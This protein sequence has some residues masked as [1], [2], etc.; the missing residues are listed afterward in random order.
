MKITFIPTSLDHKTPKGL[1]M[2][3]ALLVR[4][5]QPNQ[6]IL[7]NTKV[8]YFDRL[9]GTRGTPRGAWIS[10]RTVGDFQLSDL[11][12]G[13]IIL[14]PTSESFHAAKFIE[15]DMIVTG[16]LLAPFSAQ[17]SV[18]A[19]AAGLETSNAI[20]VSTTDHTDDIARKGLQVYHA[21]T[22]LYQSNPEYRNIMLKENGVTQSRSLVNLVSIQDADTQRSLEMTLLSLSSGFMSRNHR[23]TSAQ[24][25]LSEIPFTE[26]FQ[27]LTEEE[28]VGHFIEFS[29]M[30]SSEKIE[31]VPDSLINLIKESNEYKHSLAL[32]EQ[33]GLGISET[34]QFNVLQQ[35][36]Y[37]SGDRQNKNI[38]Y[39]LSDMGAGKTL[40]TVQSIAILDMKQVDTWLESEESV[41][42]E[43]GFR[44]PDK[45]IITPTLSVTSSWISTFKMFYDVEEIDDNT[46]R[47]ILEYR[48]R[49]V[50]SFIYVAP[51]TIR[52]GLTFVGEKLPVAAHYTYLIIDEIHQLVKKPMSKTKFFP[53]KTMPA[54]T[55]K[56]FVLSGTM[57]N[58]LSREWL[59]YMRFMGLP[60]TH[61]TPAASKLAI[62][63]LRTQMG[64]SISD[65]VGNI[66]TRHHRQI[67]TDVFTRENTHI[68]EGPNKITS[69]DEE[70]F[71]R[72]G[73]QIINP[74]FAANEGAITFENI[75]DQIDNNPGAFMTSSEDV[76]TTNFQLFYDIVG[77]QSITA[78]SSTIAEE[79]FGDQ[80]I[81]H[82]SDIIKTSSPLTS[83][84]IKILKVLHNIAEDHSQYKSLRIAKD[85]NTAILNLNDGLQTKNLYDILSS[86]AD[87]NIRFF[88]YLSTLELDVLRQLPQSNLIAMPTL[89]ETEKFQILLDILDK[90]KDETHLI[91]VN[92]FQAMT[93]ISNA[94]GVTSITRAQLR[95]ELSYQ[96]TL[97]ELFEKQSIVVVTQDMIKSS[98][99]LIQA[100]RL[101]QYQLNTEISDIIQTQNRINRI[102]QTR[103]TRG[104]YIASDAL[105]ENLIEL[106]LTSYQNIRVAHK[107]IVELFV[108]VTSQINIVNNYLSKAFETLDAG[109]DDDLIEDNQSSDVM[110]MQELSSEQAISAQNDVAQALLVPDGD[111][112]SVIVPLTDGSAFTLGTLSP[113]KV[114]EFNIAA[115]MVATIN[116]ETWE[117]EL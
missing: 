50:E 26:Y 52:G 9:P 49:K 8:T 22:G 93:K 28:Q 20:L 117:V 51:F 77:A 15:V 39:N 59:N 6:V 94:L 101:I 21:I 63:S 29:K 24:K 31:Y 76:D 107:G 82:I 35:V 67:D 54:Q 2:S 17:P 23:Q 112:V 115:P 109:E 83:E 27:L 53:P 74:H 41:T 33:H 85:I 116:I 47:L 100:N 80:Q 92:D 13:D 104:Y 5:G 98:L 18:A 44:T 1:K 81:Q 32:M 62:E 111:T 73:V 99:D 106:F 97:D 3:H 103:E 64:A 45:H 65:A 37:F 75:V 60:I 58:L 36:G 69:I 7:S 84:D 105:Q 40:M 34:Q 108:D 4:E 57:S 16:D 30:A 56:T 11:Q 55:Y 19:V 42:W 43:Y 102:G 72:Y 10:G 14:Y 61:N 96:D 110:G 87:K 114:V 68:I 38:L 46:Y 113:L 79:L 25:I 71:T 90:E 78:Q 48:G 86:A 12:D 91:V 89:E 95:D 66:R 88:E 70:F